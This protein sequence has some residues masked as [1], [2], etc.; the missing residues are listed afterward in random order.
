GFLEGS[1]VEVVTEMLDLITSQRAYEVNQ[2]V[3][4]A[5]DEMLRRTTSR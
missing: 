1:N 5:A 2:K 3:I 4:E